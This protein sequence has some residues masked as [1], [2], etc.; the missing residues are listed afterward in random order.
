MN[1]K[2]S[3]AHMRFSTI[4]QNNEGFKIKE[5]TEHLFIQL[6]YIRDKNYIYNSK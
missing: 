1:E 2:V 3:V 6:Q 5:H 4:L